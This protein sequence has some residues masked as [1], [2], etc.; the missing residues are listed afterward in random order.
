[1]WGMDLL[2]PFPRFK[3][4][5]T[6]LYVAIDH[7]T[8]WVEAK[9]VV[10]ADSKATEK[11]AYHDIICRFGIPRVLVTDNGTQFSSEYFESFW[12]RLGT[13]WA[14]EVL[15]VLWAY[16]TTPRTATGESPFSLTFG[17][18]AV[19]PIEIGIPSPCVEA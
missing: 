13:S 3:G 8:K 6:M 7:F 2:R 1:M 14:E 15:N 9:A 11:L 19:I 10:K 4:V 5:F 12:E 16:R 18:E 17:V